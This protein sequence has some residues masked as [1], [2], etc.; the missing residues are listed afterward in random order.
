LYP[1]R[2]FLLIIRP[3]S[4]SAHEHADLKPRQV[5]ETVRDLVCPALPIRPYAT[6][7]TFL[8]TRTDQN[9]AAVPFTSS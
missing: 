9:F 6:V 4:T 7:T 1:S 8:T 2:S 3:A 5:A